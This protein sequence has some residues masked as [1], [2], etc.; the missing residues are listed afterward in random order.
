M[1][2][3]GGAQNQLGGGPK[4]IKGGPEMFDL[5]KKSLI[6]DFW[7]SLEFSWKS[8]RNRPEIVWKSPEFFRKSPEILPK[9]SQIHVLA[10][11]L[12]EFY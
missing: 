8:S 9:L 7:T 2:F 12:F 5:L 10:R 4:S 11:I 3:L 6:I 1:G